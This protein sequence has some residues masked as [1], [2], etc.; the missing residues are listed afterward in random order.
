[1]LRFFFMGVGM[2]VRT[3]ARY[4]YKPRIYIGCMKSGPVLS[5]K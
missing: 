5:Q 1:M 4:R 3:L 2:L